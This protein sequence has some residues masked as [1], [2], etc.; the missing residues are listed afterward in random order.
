MSG[1]WVEREARRLC[2]CGVCSP[3]KP[4]IA[5]CVRWL[6]EM[7]LKSALNQAARVDYLPGCDNDQ[8]DHG[9]TAECLRA[10]IRALGEG[11]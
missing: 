11:T 6:T 10:A 4:P 3:P 1:S 9:E 7:A 8:C 2:G 5:G